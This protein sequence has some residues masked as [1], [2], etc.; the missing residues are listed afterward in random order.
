MNILVTG[1]AGFIGSE[2]S[3]FLIK[4]GHKVIIL[5]NLEYGYLDNIKSE[6]KLLNN[7]IKD[8]IRSVN[9][10]KIL[11]NIDVVYHFAGISSLP[12]CEANPSKAFEINCTG[13][14]RLLEAGKKEKIKKIF[15]S[16][17]SAVYENSKKKYHTED[18]IVNPNLVYSNTKRCAENICASFIENY[19]MNI[20]IFRFFNVFGPHQDFKRPYPP[21]TSY[22]IKELIN[23]K[24]PTIYNLTNSKRDYIFIDDLIYYINFFLK[25]KNKFKGEVF[26][27]CSNVGYSTKDI[28]DVMFKE[29]S[30]KN[31]YNKGDSNKFWDKYSE[32]FK[33]NYKLTRKRVKQEVFK[34]S[35]GSNKKLVKT[36][37]YKPKTNLKYAIRE[38]I[39]FQKKSM[40]GE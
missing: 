15:F 25:F 4:N 37:N 21:F 9:F 33:G 36:T 34:N 32:L 38:I 28:L 20:T 2:L 39:D 6:K 11:K 17:T 40:K 12:E 27:L 13:L 10:N 26:N 24:K 3:K 19:N 22:V 23:G 30:V 35:I 31:F 7:F 8:D 29:F 5:D 14:I 18:E 1:G 16:S